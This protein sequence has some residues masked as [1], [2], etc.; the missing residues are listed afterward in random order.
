MK[1][2][3]L[4]AVVLLLL[5]GCASTPAPKPRWA[6][7]LAQGRLIQADYAFLCG[8]QRDLARMDKR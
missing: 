5:A 3:I 7:E 8:S 6:A 2:L 4:G 1:T